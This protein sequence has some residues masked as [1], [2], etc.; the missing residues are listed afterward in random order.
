[1]VSLLAVNPRWHQQTPRQH[2]LRHRGDS[3]AACTVAHTRDR[4]FLRH[5]R[6]GLGVARGAPQAAALPIDI[7]EHVVALHTSVSLLFSSSYMN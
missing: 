3:A 5:S 1:M 2:G 4:L 7:W 6:V